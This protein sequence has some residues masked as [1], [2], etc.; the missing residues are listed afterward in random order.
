MPPT[1]RLASGYVRA[2]RATD[3]CCAVEFWNRQVIA[4]YLCVVVSY[5]VRSLLCGSKRSFRTAF[6]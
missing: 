5:C 2:L 6:P 4:L 3:E 1:Y